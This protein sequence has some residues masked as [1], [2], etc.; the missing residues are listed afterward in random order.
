MF[1]DVCAHGLCLFVVVH[2]NLFKGW[3]LDGHIGHLDAAD[4]L[5]HRVDIALEEEMHRA[6]FGLQVGHP[7]HVEAQRVQ[8]VDRQAHLLVVVLLQGADIGDFDDLALADDAHPVAQALHFAQDVRGE[9][10]GHAA[11]IFF[12]DQVEELALHQRIESAGG[13]I[14]E[15]Q[16]GA[17]QQPLH[18][19]DLLLV[20]VG[21]VADAPV[22]FQFH[23]FRQLVHALGVVARRRNWRNT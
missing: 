14:Q 17:V 2:E 21:E 16:L 11:G 6:V 18:D 15:E 19:A 4:L 22:Q 5:Q 7:G 13:F 10:D 12:A 9:E 23:R 20:A 3:L 8:P 1:V